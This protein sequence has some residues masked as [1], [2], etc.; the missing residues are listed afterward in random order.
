MSNLSRFTPFGSLARLDPF[1]SDDW[2]KGFWI[3]PFAGAL[4]AAPQIKINL[5][6]NEKSYSVRAELPGV[7]KE[8][9]KVN[10]DGN[11]VSISAESKQEKEEK[12]GDKV[13]CRECYQ[14]AVYR[15]FTLENKVD[16]S[17]AQAKFENGVLELTLPKKNGNGA[18][19]VQIK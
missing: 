3:S 17:K 15:S 13:I 14:G 18:K 10:V 5:S 19:Q 6:E 2:L 9:I 7:K 16:E 8:D 1:R 4:E 11:R 12:K